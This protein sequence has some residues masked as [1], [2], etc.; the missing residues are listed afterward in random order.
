[1]NRI[2]EVVA[3]AIPEGRG[4]SIAQPKV[5]AFPLGGASSSQERWL[6]CSPDISR[7]E[8]P[9]ATPPR[10]SLVPPTPDSPHT[11]PVCTTLPSLGPKVIAANTPP[12]LAPLRKKKDNGF[13]SSGSHLSPGQ[14]APKVQT[15]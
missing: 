8:N 4:G 13:I 12:V 15:P 6:L 11:T 14:R 7:P 9:T 5:I 3:R 10:L 1:M 2:S